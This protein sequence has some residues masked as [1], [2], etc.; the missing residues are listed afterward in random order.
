MLFCRLR[1]KLADDLDV[2]PYMVA[3]NIAL[4]QIVER[5][6]QT[7][8]ELRSCKL[9]GFYEA[10]YL[11]FGRDILKCVRETSTEN[12]IKRFKTEEVKTQSQSRDTDS[13]RAFWADDATDADLSQI[14][15]DLE[16]Q[17]PSLGPSFYKKD[18]E[19]KETTKLKSHKEHPAP[20][21]DFWENDSLDAQL[22]EIGNEVEKQL[23][24]AGPE[25]DEYSSPKTELDLL[26]ADLQDVQ[27]E[28]DCRKS[29]SDSASLSPKKPPISY[30]S[31]MLKKKPIYQYEDDSS[32]DNS[33]NGSRVVKPEVTSNAK[34]GIQKQR[35]L[36][37]WMQTKH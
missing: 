36:P 29:N 31:L 16:K 12:D 2:I 32:D 3:S 21:S 35:V 28:I 23:H 8:E 18:G 19:T 6:P 25:E 5:K 37:A 4:D 30:Y 26:L 22:C 34:T 7:L 27:K 24:S 20:A 11:R 9:D 15:T 1:G 33:D 14:S 13:L 10:K 17:L